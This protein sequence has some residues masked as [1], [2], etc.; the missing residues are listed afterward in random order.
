MYGSG[1]RGGI[2]APTPG[3]GKDMSLMSQT[4]GNSAALD[5]FAQSKIWGAVSSALFAV[6]S[7]G[8]SLA[9]QQPGAQLWH[10][11]IS[12]EARP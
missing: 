11:C 5:P 10:G 8:T 2:G 7:N 9:V 3:G 4:F 1:L 12:H 6:Q